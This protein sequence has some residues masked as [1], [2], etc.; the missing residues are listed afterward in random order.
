MALRWIILSSQRFRDSYQQYKQQT[1]SGKG[2]AKTD[3]TRAEALEILGLDAAASREEIIAAH[4]RL[5]QKFHPDRGGS[6][7]LAKKI[8]M[9]K[10]VLLR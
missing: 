3:M 6:P 7:A 5:I 9:A 10:E 2:H 1:D 4:K 8:N